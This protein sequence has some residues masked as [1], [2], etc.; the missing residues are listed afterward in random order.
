MPALIDKFRY[1]LRAHKLSPAHSPRVILATMIIA[2]ALVWLSTMSVKEKEAGPSP[3]QSADTFVPEGFVLVPIEVENHQ[4]L[5]SIL[6]PYGVV[7]LYAS[8]ME[9]G[10]KPQLVASRIKILRAP[11]NPNSFAVL[12]PSEDAPK[13]VRSGQFIVV[14]KNPKERGTEVNGVA[15]PAKGR[16][17]IIVE[18]VL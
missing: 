1:H 13:L 6:G 18:T 17:R 2:G 12:S 8:A 5:D 14:V 3:Q 15:A 4:A 7:D 16:S 9:S 10:K 11:L